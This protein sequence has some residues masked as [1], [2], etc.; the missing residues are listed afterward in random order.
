M[1][2]SFLPQWIVFLVIFALGDHFFIG[3]AA[4]PKVISTTVGRVG[5]R[6][7]TSREVAISYLLEQALF[8]KGP[9]GK[10]AVKDLM[11]KSVKDAVA[12]VL[13]EWV[14][15]LEAQ[16]FSSK[17]IEDDE[18]LTA[19]KKAVSK[20]KSVA[21]WKDLQV[22]HGE[23]RQIIQR[24]L[25]SKEF[26]RFRIDSSYIPITDSEVRAYFEENR[27]QF[28]QLPYESFEKNIRAFLKKRQVEQR[29]KDWFDVLQR[30]YKVNRYL[31]EL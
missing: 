23:L 25:R 31:V 22:D 11:Q 24:K 1:N 30:K 17:K 13:M 6:V 21:E 7:V 29:L 14:V 16:K 5:D 27:S 15:Y 8:S 2:G 12:G 20:L 19:E 3:T 18:L 26:I 4:T 9:I 10:E 28:G